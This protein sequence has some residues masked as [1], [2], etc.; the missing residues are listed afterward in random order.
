MASFSGIPV[1]LAT[2]LERQLEEA[3]FKRTGKI[4][5]RVTNRK[6]DVLSVEL[7]R[8]ALCSKWGLPYGSFTIEPACFLPFVPSLEAAD[9]HCRRNTNIKLRSYLDCQIR[10]AVRRHILQKEVSKAPNIWF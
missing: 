3:D 2:I 7:I 1:W 10:F 9:F 8:R 5:H 6:I 4:A